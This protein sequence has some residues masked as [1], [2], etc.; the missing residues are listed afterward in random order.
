M[1]GDA[2]HATTP[3]EG[4]GATLQKLRQPRSV[5]MTVENTESS[6]S[7]HGNAI[8][9]SEPDFGTNLDWDQWKP[10]WLT[11]GYVAGSGGGRS[12]PREFLSVTTWKWSSQAIRDF[13][14]HC[15][16]EKQNNEVA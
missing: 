2:A 11:R 16:R 3:F 7:N 14:S 8:I 9:K 10:F 5:M 6:D 15:F 1:M 12:D 4:Q 13:F